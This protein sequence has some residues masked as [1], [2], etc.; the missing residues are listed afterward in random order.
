MVATMGD[1]LPITAEIGT[2]HD[3]VIDRVRPPPRSA[4]P[5]DAVAVA[6][7]TRLTARPTQ[8]TTTIERTSRT[9]RGAPSRP[10]ASLPAMSHNTAREPAQSQAWRS[11][12]R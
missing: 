6:A 5:D 8:A 12:L 3:F 10:V 7:R 1:D 9:R 4:L 11:D 2:V